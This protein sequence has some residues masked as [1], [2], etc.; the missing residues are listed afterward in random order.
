M[1]IQIRGFIVTDYLHKRAEVLGI[2]RKAVEEGTLVFGANSEQVVPTK[3]ED[4]P[5]TWDKIV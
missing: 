1:R 3:F 2:F 5:K 4:I